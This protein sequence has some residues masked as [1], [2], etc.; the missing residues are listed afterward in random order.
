MEFWYKN[1]LQTTTQ[2]AVTSGTLLGYFMMIRDPRRQWVSDSQSTDAS[3]ASIT[4]SFDPAIT[5]DRVALDNINWKKFNVYYNGATANA[6]TMTTTA[7]TTTSQWTTNSETSMVI[8]CSTVTGVSSLTFDIYSTQIADKE[9]AIGWLCVS[10]KRMDFEKVPDAQSYDPVLNVEQK[11][12]KL[13]D[14]G[15][16]I[17]TIE[18]K[19]HAT[20]KLKYI[21]SSFKDELYSIWRDSDPFIFA[22]FS[23][24]TGWDGIAYEV[25]WPGKFDFLE[26]ADNNADAGFKGT[27]TMKEVPT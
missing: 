27:I 6:L 23:T 16:R 14:G 25:V 18:R 9:K 22:P 10:N 17:H 12:H 2:I 13:S 21:D 26:Y 24:S 19:F 11:E 15:V 8:V 5:I 4:I 1:Q 20:I 7:A 3:T